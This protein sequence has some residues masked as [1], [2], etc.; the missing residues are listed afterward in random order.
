MKFDLKPTNE[1][2]DTQWIKY[3]ETLKENDE[4]EI[5]PTKIIWHDENNSFLLIDDE[6]KVATAVYC[7]HHEKSEFTDSIPDGV[8]LANA[9]GRS[10]AIT[11]DTTGSDLVETANKNIGFTVRVENTE[12]GLSIATIESGY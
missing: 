11:G 3:Y 2:N 10:M 4:F 7:Q 6:N 1:M 8:R 5:V 12:K 9:L